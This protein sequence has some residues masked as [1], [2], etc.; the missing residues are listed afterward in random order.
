MSQVGQKGVISGDLTIIGQGECSLKLAHIP[1][2]HETFALNLLLKMIQYSFCGPF[3]GV[4]EVTMADPSDCRKVSLVK[5][6][7]A[8]QTKVVDLAMT[9][10]CDIS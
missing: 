3:F 8:L 6:N 10:L 9:I 7:G 1:R 4:E 2:M 5:H